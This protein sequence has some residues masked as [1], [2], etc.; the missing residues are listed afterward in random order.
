[1]DT[2]DPAAAALGDGSLPVEDKASAFG[3]EKLLSGLLVQIT[4]NGK[5]IFPEFDAD[6]V[7]LQDERRII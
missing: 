7:V 3:T 6:Q 5:I 1:M 2:F 4:F